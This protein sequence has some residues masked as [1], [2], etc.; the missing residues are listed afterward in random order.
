MIYRIAPSALKIIDPN[1][2]K[3]YYPGKNYYPHEVPEHMRAGHF[4]EIDGPE[5]P[6]AVPKPHILLRE[7]KPRKH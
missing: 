1:T 5:Q 3:E 6:A 4:V 2:G 7:P